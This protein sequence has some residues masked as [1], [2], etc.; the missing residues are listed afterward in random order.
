[1]DCKYHCSVFI[2]PRVASTIRDK[3]LKNDGYSQELSTIHPG[4]GRHSD[5]A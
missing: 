4:A 3:Y 1:M 5:H 2:N